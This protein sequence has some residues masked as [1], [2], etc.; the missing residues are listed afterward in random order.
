MTKTYKLEL[1]NKKTALISEEQIKA[2]AHFYQINI[3]ADFLTEKYPN[4]SE[5]KIE[6][7]ADFIQT[8]IDKYSLDDIYDMNDAVK[9]FEH[10][11]YPRHKEKEI[12]ELEYE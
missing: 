3:I 2:I 12:E 6:L 11:Y 4:W 9:V 10:T 8:E 5:A 7:A 1:P